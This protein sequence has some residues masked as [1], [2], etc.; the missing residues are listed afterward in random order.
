MQHQSAFPGC[1]AE[2]LLDGLYALWGA[3]V[4]PS[5]CH[6]RDLDHAHALLGHPKGE[7]PSA[8]KSS[9]KTTRFRAHLACRSSRRARRACALSFSAVA[10]ALSSQ[11]EAGPAGP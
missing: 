8:C 1:V 2:D 6:V 9:A 7:D 5:I 10:L 11:R 4:G 3:Q